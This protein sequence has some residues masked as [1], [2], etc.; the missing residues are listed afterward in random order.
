[1]KQLCANCPATLPGHNPEG[2]QISH[3]ICETCLTALYGPELT[4]RVLQ[5]V[6]TRVTTTHQPTFA[7]QMFGQSNLAFKGGLS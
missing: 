3:G 2:T 4:A 6:Q 5:P 1:M 7:E